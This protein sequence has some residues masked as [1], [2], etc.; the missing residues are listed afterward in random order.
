MLVTGAGVRTASDETTGFLVIG[1][2]QRSQP[3]LFKQLVSGLNEILAIESY[4]RMIS[5]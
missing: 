1:F 3:R 5:T 2:E 4:T